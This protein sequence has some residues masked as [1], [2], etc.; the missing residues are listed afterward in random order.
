MSL[1]RGFKAEANRIAVRLRKDLGLAP[2]DPMDLG[3]LATKLG[4]PIVA[5]S[6]FSRE[7]AGAVH[8]LMH[9]DQG[10]FSA[11]TIPCGPSDRI[12]LHNDS[13][14]PPRQRSNIAHEFA[15]IVLCHPMTL[16]LDN[17][18]CRN[19]D[20]DVEDEANWLG[21]TILVPD[22]AALWIVRTRTGD[23]EA[24]QRYGVSQELLR[25]R[26]NASGARIRVSRTRR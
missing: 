11:V 17:T 8:H 2:E 15:H 6:A 20:C 10:A 14:A 7:C 9:I 1:R 3:A 26:V 19:I 23:A 25:F 24:C 5:L 12:I 16:P 4:V 13:H 21:A 22:A 18:G